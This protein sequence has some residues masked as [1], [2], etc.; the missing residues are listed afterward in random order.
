MPYLTDFTHPGIDDVLGIPLR[1]MGGI[2]P[3]HYLIILLYFKGLRL[4]KISTMLRAPNILIFSLLL[5]AL[6]ASAAGWN[7]VQNGTSGIL[8][9]EAIIV[10]PT[11][12]VFFD[13]ASNDPLMINNN[14]A[15]GALWNLET[16]TASPLLVIS[17]TFC[18]SGGFLSNGT[19]VRT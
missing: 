14:P 4:E 13:R 18:A 12:A 15:W 8:A 19:M 6:S 1:E 7:F 11:L 5:N 2:K 17:D 3:S 10:S 16:N 9:L